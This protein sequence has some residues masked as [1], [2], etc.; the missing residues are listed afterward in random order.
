MALLVLFK[1]L[2][3]V[4]PD[5]EVALHVDNIHH[6][7]TSIAHVKRYTCMSVWL[8]VR[9]LYAWYLEHSRECC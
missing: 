9:A 3:E 5:E 7:S 1:F 6:C 8:P 2:D 4:L